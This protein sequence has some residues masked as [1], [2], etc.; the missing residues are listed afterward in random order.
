MPKKSRKKSKPKVKKSSL[1]KAVK[2]SVKKKKTLK[3]KVI[4]KPV[5]KIAKRVILTPQNRI[6]LPGSERS[7]LLG[8]RVVGPVDPGERILVTVVV[9]P[10]PSSKELTS[11]IEEIGASRPLERK[12]LSREEFAASHGADPRDLK[13]VEAFAHD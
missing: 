13:K 4:K 10:R 1:H 8:A 6:P 11:M 3:K 2:K 9:R 12:H 7:A 5:K